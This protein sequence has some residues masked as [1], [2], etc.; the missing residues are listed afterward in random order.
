MLIRWLSAVE[1]I[2]H[3]VRHFQSIYFHVQFGLIMKRLNVGGLYYFTA[4]QK[5]A[6]PY[7]IS[8]ELSRG[9]QKAA[10]PGPLGGEGQNNWAEE[11]GELQFVKYA[12]RLEFS[13]NLLLGNSVR[14]V[15][16]SFQI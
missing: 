8:H 13:F 14:L 6:L 16:V 3:T 7:A 11:G 1:A 2:V 15:L 10:S 9:E 5:K 12:T 4:T